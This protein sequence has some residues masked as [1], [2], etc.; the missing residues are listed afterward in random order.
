MDKVTI[1][2]TVGPRTDI[3]ADGNAIRIRSE[4][5]WG[6]WLTLYVKDTTTAL[7]LEMVARDIRERLSGAD[8]MQL[9]ETAA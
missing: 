9:V 5:G 8:P 7:R 4:D 3:R 1:Q 6:P 2:A